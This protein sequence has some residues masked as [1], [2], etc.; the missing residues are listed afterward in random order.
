MSKIR[1]PLDW[2]HNQAYP[3]RKSADVALDNDFNPLG[4]RQFYQ[5]HVGFVSLT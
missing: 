4:L 5:L 2:L 1:I 3:I